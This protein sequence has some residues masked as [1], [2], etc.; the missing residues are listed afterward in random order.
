ML[1][2]LGYTNSEIELSK[3]LK[4]DDRLCFLC[5][6]SNGNTPKHNTLR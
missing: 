1:I 6:F 5:E 2:Y 3:R 4:F